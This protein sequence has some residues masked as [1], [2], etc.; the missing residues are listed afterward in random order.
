MPTST[1]RRLAA[2]ALQAFLVDFIAEL[3]AREL[4]DEEGSE[5]SDDSDDDMDSSGS[6]SDFL[7]SSS[8]YSLE[9]EPSA[10]NI[11][12][13]LFHSILGSPCVTCD[14]PE[15]ISDLSYLVCDK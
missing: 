3:E 7:E 4:L 11:Y 10:A 1:E 8:S 9:N 12:T 14:Q 15:E 2:D 6:S 13:V 5:G